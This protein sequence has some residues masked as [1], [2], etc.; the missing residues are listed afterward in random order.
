[1]ALLATSRSGKRRRCTSSIFKVAMK[2]SAI[3]LSKAVPF[4]PIEGTMPS[5][6]RRLPKEIAVYWADSIG[7][8][9]TPSMEVW[10][11]TTEGLEY[12]DDRPGTDAFAGTSGREP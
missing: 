11:G 2:L 12:D 9:N 4:L 6:A 7:R 1:M 3:A 8:S 10:N 5:S